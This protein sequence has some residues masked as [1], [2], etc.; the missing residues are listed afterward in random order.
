[1]TLPLL[2]SVP[3]AGLTVPPGAEAY[4]V[5]T[6]EQIAKDGDEQAA[7]IYD[8]ENLVAKYVTSPIARAIV[9]LNRGVD[10]RR[11][12]GVV[13]THTCWN[14][15][16]YEPFP[17]E[18]LIEALL[19]KYYHPYH[20]RL[21][22][23]ADASLKLAIDCHTMAAKGPP[24]GP[25]PGRERPMV[26]ISNAGFSCPDAVLRSMA[27]CFERAF[28]SE[29]AINTPFLG[30]YITRTHAAEMPWLQLEISRA[31]ALPPAEKRRRVIEA[32]TAWCR[33]EY[34]AETNDP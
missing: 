18:D 26:C 7:E 12:D 29:V 15:P 33:N 4:C 24:V 28:D 9:D 27:G 22:Q 13:K 8:F 14:E 31:P 1:M 16:V 19:T 23:S 32:L 5:L 30:G 11:S 21:S 6:A 34:P 3:H 25:D 10:D 17:P 2:I 20:E